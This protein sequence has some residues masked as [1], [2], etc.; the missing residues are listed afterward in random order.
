MDSCIPRSHAS[1][2]SCPERPA[3]LHAPWTTFPWAALMCFHCP[4]HV[5]LLCWR[6]PSINQP[7]LVVPTLII[8]VIHLRLSLHSILRWHV[9]PCNHPA[10]ICHGRPHSYLQMPRLII[11]YPATSFNCHLRKEGH[12]V[13]TANPVYPEHPITSLLHS[14]SALGYQLFP[15]LPAN[16]LE[17]AYK[18]CPLQY[19]LIF[20]TPASRPGDAC[21]PL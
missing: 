6:L 9:R 2:M 17:S 19:T 16:A 12:G 7:S 5:A 8:V 20:T 11:I 10:A 13:G 1:S 14:A 15:D 21:L 18:H 3:L 4:R